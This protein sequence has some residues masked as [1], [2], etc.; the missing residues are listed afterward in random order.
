M[1]FEHV[2]VF[3]KNQKKRAK[4]IFSVVLQPYFLKFSPPV[5]PSV[6]SIDRGQIH[7]YYVKK[8]T[9]ERLFIYPTSGVKI[10]VLTPQ[11]IGL[12]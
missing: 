7:Q 8:I 9:Y 1:G 3:R 6:P 2:K 5:P 11:K 10:G 12:L 4:K